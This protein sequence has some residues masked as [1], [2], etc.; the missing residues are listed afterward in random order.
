M[1]K[2]D[3]MTGIH[4]GT[5]TGRLK[6]SKSPVTAALQSLMVTFCFVSFCQR[7]S[8][9]TADTMDKAVSSSTRS[10]KYMVENTRTG[11]SEKM[12]SFIIED[13]VC[14]ARTWGEVE[15]KS[16]FVSALI[17]YFPPGH[18]FFDWPTPSSAPTS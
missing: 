14:S 18:A 3:P 16:L 1:A 7:Y 11:S 4:H 5:D 12:T 15:T 13:V 10:P 9:T 6:A 8:E 17:S 2:A